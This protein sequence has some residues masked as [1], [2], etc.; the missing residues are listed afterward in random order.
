MFDNI[1]KVDTKDL[2]KAVASLVALSLKPEQLNKVLVR[3][4]QEKESYIAPG[5][6]TRIS[7]V[8]IYNPERT[9]SEVVY[10]NGDRFTV[11]LD[12]VKL[13]EQIGLKTNNSES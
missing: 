6:I 8:K 7:T 4:N 9:A 1:Q 3:D 13:G 12:P 2:A 5:L 11:D 10:V